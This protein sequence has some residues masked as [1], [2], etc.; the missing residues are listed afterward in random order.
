M[1]DVITCNKFI[2]SGKFRVIVHNQYF[3]IIEIG[4][5]AIHRKPHQ[6]NCRDPHHHCH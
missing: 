5:N 2:L 1:K 3:G 6:P 4:F